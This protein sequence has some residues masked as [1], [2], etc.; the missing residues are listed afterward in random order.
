MIHPLLSAPTSSESPPLRRRR[1]LAHTKQDSLTPVEKHSLIRGELLQHVGLAELL[2]HPQVRRLV[3]PGHDR[4]GIVLECAGRAC[5]E[6][7]F[8]KNISLAFLSYHLL[9]NALKAGVGP[10]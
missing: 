5:D 6:L 8:A 10:W 2:R 3:G 7:L 1:K 9:V 4:D